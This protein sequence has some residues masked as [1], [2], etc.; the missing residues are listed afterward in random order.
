MKKDKKTW[1]SPSMG[2]K[3]KVN[4]YGHAG[5]PVLFF[6][7]DCDKTKTDEKF[8]ESVQFQIEEGMNMVFTLEKPDYKI[9][10]DEKMDPNKRLLHYLHIESFVI[11]ELVPRM[12]K[13]TGR[14][15]V[16]LSGVGDGG[17]LAANMLLKHPSKFQKCIVVCARYDMRP[18]FDGSE[19]ED[20][21]YNNPIEF[22]PHLNDEFF[23]TDLRKS[24]FRLISHVNDPMLE[25]ADRISDFLYN[26]QIDHVLDIWGA[27][28][29]L[30]TDTLKEMYAKHIP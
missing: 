18:W 7:S 13:E 28:R 26:K 22:L 8:L 27:E 23:L 14:D 21:Y 24:D 20:F 6:N 30:D 19:D 17:F 12:C 4:T 2:S 29:E 9:I 15:F 11:D 25:Q 3:V 10:F 5:T 16:I 1:S